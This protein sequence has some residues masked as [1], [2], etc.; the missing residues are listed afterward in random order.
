[1]KAAAKVDWSVDLRVPLRAGSTAAQKV[2][3]KA[4]RKAGSWVDLKEPWTA[5]L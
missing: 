3:L 1:M 5:D 4:V 2:Y